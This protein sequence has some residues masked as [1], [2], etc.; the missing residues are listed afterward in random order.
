MHLQFNP[1]YNSLY[2]LKQLAETDESP[3]ILHHLEKTLQQSSLNNSYQDDEDAILNGMKAISAM[4]R[5]ESL[6]RFVLNSLRLP[7]VPDSI[8]AHEVYTIVKRLLGNILAE[9]RLAPAIDAML[10]E[11]LLFIFTEEEGCLW[12][13]FKGTIV[14]CR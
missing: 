8:E 9:T 1:S 10:I 12:L 14:F 13:G 2:A 5:I 3:K 11:R 4:W 6:S 7:K